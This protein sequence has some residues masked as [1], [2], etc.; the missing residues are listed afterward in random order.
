MSD[1]LNNATRQQPFDGDPYKVAAKYLDKIFSLIPSYGGFDI[2][3]IIDNSDLPA[4]D[5][6]I[7][8]YVHSEMVDILKSENCLKIPSDYGNLV[9][10]LTQQGRDVLAA[11]NLTAYKNKK[12]K[13]ENSQSVTNNH[14][15]DNYGQV[16]QG[17]HQSSFDLD[18]S[19]NLPNS[20]PAIQTQNIAQKNGDLIASKIFKYITNHIVQ[21]IIGLIIG[22]LIFRFGWT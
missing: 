21:I 14:Y 17:G 3:K 12:A 22:Y 6:V 5:K 2:Q 19:K 1:L 7:A 10:Q 4:S 15:G 16:M 8:D 9:L 20:Q 13:A 11:G 18:F